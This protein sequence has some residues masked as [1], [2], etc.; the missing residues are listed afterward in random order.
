MH[1]YVCF[2]HPECDCASSHC[3]VHTGECLPESYTVNLCNIS[4]SVWLEI[5]MNV[6]V[7]LKQ[8]FVLDFSMM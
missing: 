7:Y 1:V 3:D 8:P 4:K 2:F 6:S 5:K